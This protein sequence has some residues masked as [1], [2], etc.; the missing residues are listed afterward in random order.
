[1]RPRARS[2]IVSPRLREAE[3]GHW[4]DGGVTASINGIAPSAQL[5]RAPS[6]LPLLM[7]ATLSAI[8]DASRP[9]AGGL[10]SVP[11]RSRALDHDRTVRCRGTRSGPNR[12]GPSRTAPSSA[13]FFAT[14]SRQS[15]KNLS[16]RYIKVDSIVGANRAKS[17]SLCPSSQGE[18]SHAWRSAGVAKPICPVGHPRVSAPPSA[19]LQQN[20]SPSPR[21]QPQ[22]AQVRPNGKRVPASVGLW[23]L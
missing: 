19:R 21:S 14:P 8:Q 2:A 16:S 13:W 9:T 15:R 23:H 4:V 6:K 7:Q 10:M 18:G 20:V 17:F 1:M 22:P 5:A 12:P 3:I 11:A